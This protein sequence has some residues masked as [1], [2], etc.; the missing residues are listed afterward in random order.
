MKIELQSK[1]PT[2]NTW[3]IIELNQIISAALKSDSLQDLK[4][5]LIKNYPYEYFEYGFGGSHAWVKLKVKGIL[6]EE[7]TLFIY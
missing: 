7:R 2:T 4:P 3:Q 1:L 5:A 6:S